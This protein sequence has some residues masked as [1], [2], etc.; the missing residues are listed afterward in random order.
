[1]IDSD[2]EIELDWD[3]IEECTD[4]PLDE[5]EELLQYMYELDILLIL[6]FEDGIIG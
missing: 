6:D 1:M 2:D 3:D 4:M 5:A